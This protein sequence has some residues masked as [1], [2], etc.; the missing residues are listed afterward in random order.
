MKKKIME[1]D[2]SKNE[3]VDLEAAFRIFMTRQMFPWNEILCTAEQ[4]VA[5]D[6]RQLAED[7]L[8]ELLS[9]SEWTATAVIQKVQGR[10]ESWGYDK[11]LD[12]TRLW[13][14]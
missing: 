3:Q 7:K 1:N 5:K 12:H 6:S 14:N 4:T 2:R 9:R 13:V 8:S 11:E 10:A